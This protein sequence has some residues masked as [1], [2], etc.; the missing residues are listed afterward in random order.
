MRWPRPGGRHLWRLGAV[1]PPPVGLDPWLLAGHTAL[2]VHADPPPPPP[3]PAHWLPPRPPTPAIEDAGPSQR[4]P[5]YLPVPMRTDVTAE[6]A[7]GFVSAPTG[8]SGVVRL[9]AG[10]EG[11][12]ANAPPPQEM[13]AGPSSRAERRFG[14]LF[15]RVI[16]S[17]DRQ[18]G[19]RAGLWA[20]ASLGLGLGL[21]AVPQDP[22]IV[23]SSSDEEG[24]SVPRR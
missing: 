4:P 23:S 19:R 9:G 16:A 20:P 7:L 1:A 10:M 18:P 11:V 12:V 2:M 5:G 6:E 13:N 24:S 3:P 8:A 21:G 14:R 15:G 22:V 17:L